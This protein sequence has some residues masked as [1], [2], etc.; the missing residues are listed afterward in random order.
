MTA[1]DILL[2]AITVAGLSFV[3]WCIDSLRMI[4]RDGWR[5]HPRRTLALSAFA[6]LWLALMYVFLRPNAGPAWEQAPI[7]GSIDQREHVCLPTPAA[8]ARAYYAYLA[9]R[10]TAFGPAGEPAPSDP[11]FN[12]KSDAVASA[13][14]A[15]QHDYV[16]AMLPECSLWQLVTGKE[17]TR[18]QRAAR[19]TCLTNGADPD[20]VALCTGITLRRR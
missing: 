18:E 2:A 4:R 17:L 20:I 9:R 1:L 16:S 11:K 12:E 19:V 3:V 15:A 5:E 8:E 10:S 14:Q 7:V 6:V 13:L